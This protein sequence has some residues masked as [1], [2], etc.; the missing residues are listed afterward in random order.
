MKLPD[1]CVI[2]QHKN[3]QDGTYV[4]SSGVLTMLNEGGH[5]FVDIDIRELVTWL[6]LWRPDLLEQLTFDD[7]R[8]P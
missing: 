7:A 8:K 5:N 1:G 4:S 3:D 6:R 2:V